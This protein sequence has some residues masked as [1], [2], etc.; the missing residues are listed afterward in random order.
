MPWWLFSI[1]CLVAVFYFNDYYEVLVAGLLIDSLYNTSPHFWG[2]AWSISA[3]VIFL[4]SF[5]L[6]KRLKFY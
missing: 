4:V 3:V 1:L 5:S 2:F 6:K